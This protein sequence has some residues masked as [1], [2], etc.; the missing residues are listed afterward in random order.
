VKCILV[1]SLKISENS[2][3]II[4]YRCWTLYIACV[5]V[6]CMLFM[7]WIYF[8]LLV[9]EDTPVFWVVGALNLVEIDWCFRG[10]YCLYR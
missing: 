8:S 1:Y 4:L 5:Y 9:S 3:F 6:L 7:R 10:A 2:Y